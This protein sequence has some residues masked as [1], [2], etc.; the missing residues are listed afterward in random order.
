M[1]VASHI[2]PWSESNNTKHLDG[3]NGLLLPPHIDK[4]LDRGWITFSDSG[5]LR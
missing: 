1:P 5:D 4:L 2:K 3:N